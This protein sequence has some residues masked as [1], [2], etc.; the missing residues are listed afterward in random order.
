MYRR[1][2]SGIIAQGQTASFLEAM[3]DSTQYQTDRGIRQRTT[4]WGAMTG[5]TNSVLIASDFNTLEELE[6]FS[7][8]TTHD[9][10]FARVRRAVREHM[11]FEHSD[12][13]IHRLAYHSD[14]LMSSEDATAPRHFMRTLTGHVQAGHHRD[15]VMSISEALEYQKKR[16]IDATTSVWSAVTGATNGVAI[17]AEFDSL[18]ALEKFDE[19]AAQ[20]PSFAEHRRATRSNMVFLTSHVDLM[21]NLL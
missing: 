5:Q 9:A 13:N 15:F 6:K 12:V 17:V 16:G 7:D 3:R 14:G 10:R 20:D 18:S 21:R 4:I 1:L 11:V 2:L 8:L 19:M